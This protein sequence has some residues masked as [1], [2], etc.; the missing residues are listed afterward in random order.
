MVLY[1]LILFT[2]SISW[3][4]NKY[5]L[6]IV[7]V[8]LRWVMKKYKYSKIICILTFILICIF[9]VFMFIEISQSYD[10]PKILL[11]GEVH[12]DPV[13]MEKELELWEKSYNEDG[14]RNLFIEMSYCD[15]QLLN[16]WMKDDN[17]KILMQIYDNLDGTLAHNEYWLGFY[18]YIK[19]NF[20]ETV[21]YGNDVVHQQKT[22]ELYLNYLEENGMENSDEYN[23]ALK[24]IEQGK[25]YY[26]GNQKSYENN[27]D[28]DKKQ[29]SYGENENIVYRE[30]M[31]AE[32]FIRMYDGLEDKRVMGFY[33]RLHTELEWVAEEDNGVK[34][35]SM[36]YQ[37]TERYGDDVQCVVVKDLI[38]LYEFKD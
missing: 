4:K 33:G 28:S 18:K 5:S 12:A 30:N 20:P 32:N 21:F 15:A 38:K 19:V 13:I 31:L 29:S 14:M 27:I 3:K 10:E 6:D 1:F 11:Y 25:F 36:A 23:I 26:E 9:G 22:A 2:V 7:L 24:N 34:A 35:N 8:K 16:I 37:L 17:D